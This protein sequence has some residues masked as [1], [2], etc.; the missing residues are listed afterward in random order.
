MDKGLKSLADNAGKFNYLMNTLPTV[1]KDALD[2]Y[3]KTLKNNGTLIQVGLPDSDEPF[4]ISYPTLILKQVKL[5]GSVV[6]S[7]QETKDTLAFTAD[8]NIRVAV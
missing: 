5:T 2:G 4:D 7:V 1:T 8:H 6:S 3:L